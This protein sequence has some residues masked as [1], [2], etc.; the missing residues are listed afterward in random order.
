M[1]QV[2]TNR[3]QI[4]TDG[5]NSLLS[6]TSG[7]KIPAGS[8]RDHVNELF[9]DTALKG[10]EDAGYEV[11]RT[12][13]SISLAA[14]NNAP[15]EKQFGLTA[16][17]MDLQF[18]NEAVREALID[19]YTLKTAEKKLKD[20]EDA[21][22]TILDLTINEIVTTTQ[23]MLNELNAARHELLATEKKAKVSFDD[24]REWQDAIEKQKKLPL[25]PRP[26]SREE[27]IAAI[28]GQVQLAGV[29]IQLA[30][31]FA[32]NYIGHELGK[33]YSDPADAALCL[34]C[35]TLAGASFGAAPA[36]LLEFLAPQLIWL[37]RNGGIRNWLR[38]INRQ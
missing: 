17:G 26:L 2:L 32:G 15:Q 37:H 13:G 3:Q 20:A 28:R 30:G 12:D 36:P 10:D 4:R 7:L 38:E 29:A 23:T 8:W 25:L 5:Q 22:S 16:L 14:I 34:T 9:G 33:F 18:R 24:A 31:A 6:S 35:F 11:C 19:R 21:I 1:E 27:E